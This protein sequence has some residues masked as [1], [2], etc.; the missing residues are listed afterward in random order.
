MFEKKKRITI[1][2]LYPNL[3]PEEKTEAEYNLREYAL[4]VWRIYERV[5]RENPELL[6]K[7]LKSDRV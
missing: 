7:M 5:K 3:S 6:T 4:L 1:Q 2:D